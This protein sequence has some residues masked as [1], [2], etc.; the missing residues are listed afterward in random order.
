MKKGSR[1]L[2]QGKK[3]A[4]NHDMSFQARLPLVPVRAALKGDYSYV[5]ECFSE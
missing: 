5:I 2:P 3:S 4:S 1:T